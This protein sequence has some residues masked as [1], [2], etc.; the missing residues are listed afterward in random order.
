MTLELPTAIE[1]VPDGKNYYSIAVATKQFVGIYRNYLNTIL[2]ANTAL[3][4]PF[5]LD[6]NENTVINIIRF[7][8]DNNK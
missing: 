8:Y 7:I 2:N 4:Y 1:Y 3:N 6:T 5:I